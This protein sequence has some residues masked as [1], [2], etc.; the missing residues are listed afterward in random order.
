MPFN[1]PGTLVPLYA[2]LNPRLLLPSLAV[3]RISP[4][5]HY[6]TL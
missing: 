3:V 4:S 6:R 2:L 1:L 5:I